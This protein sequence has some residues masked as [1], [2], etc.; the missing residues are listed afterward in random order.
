VII[1][2][3]VENKFMFLHEVLTRSGASTLLLW[4]C[5]HGGFKVLTSNEQT[6]VDTKSGEAWLPQSK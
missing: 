6:Q 3:F 5:G 2:L 4:Q 1:Y